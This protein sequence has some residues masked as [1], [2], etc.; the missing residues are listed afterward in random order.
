VISLACLLN[1]SVETI[2]RH[3]S[4]TPIGS[5]TLDSSNRAVSLF[6][7]CCQ[8]ASLD[9]SIKIGDKCNRLRSVEWVHD[10]CTAH[11]RSTGRAQQRRIHRVHGFVLEKSMK[12]LR[13]DAGKI[14]LQWKDIGPI[15][16]RVA[17]RLAQNEA[18]NEGP[19]QQVAQMSG[20]MAKSKIG[21]SPLLGKRDPN[22][23]ARRAELK[24]VLHSNPYASALEI[25]KRWDNS[26]SSTIVPRSLQ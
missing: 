13:E 21:R 7:R 6:I 23:A 26:E 11:S 20:S 14:G 15:I 25:C 24:N 4:V 5:K 10:E 18:R 12:K 8:L 16:R 17:N 22:V 19:G 3:A 9:R 1:A 2:T